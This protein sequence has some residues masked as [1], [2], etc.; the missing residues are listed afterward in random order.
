MAKKV[1]NPVYR[2]IHYSKVSSLLFTFGDVMPK[3]KLYRRGNGPSRFNS[4]GQF[5][6]RGLMAHPG[7][8]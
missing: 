7:G 1:A 3:D 4:G 2:K 8:L 5:K 6:F